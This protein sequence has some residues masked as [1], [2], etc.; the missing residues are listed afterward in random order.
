MFYIHCVGFEPYSACLRSLFDW[1][2]MQ[3]G[4]SGTVLLSLGAKE[5]GLIRQGQWW[6]FF[7]PQYLH[8]GL[9]HLGM[10]MLVLYGLT[11]DKVHRLL[12]LSCIL[13]GEFNFTK[14]VN[15]YSFMLAFI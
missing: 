9:V 13:N 10:N 2:H 1:C 12:G 8:G 7:A 14:G 15:C 5:A 11:C 6:R 3:F 4:P